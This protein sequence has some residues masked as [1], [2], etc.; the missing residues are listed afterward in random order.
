MTTA[1]ETVS[2]FDDD[3]DGVIERTDPAELAD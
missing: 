2:S 3:F 1:V